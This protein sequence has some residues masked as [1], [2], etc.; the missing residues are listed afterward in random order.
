MSGYTADIV[1]KRGIL[2]EET[3]FISKPAHSG[4]ITKSARSAGPEI[5]KPAEHL[6]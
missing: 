2:E 4:V 6:K 1:Q 3:D 5:M